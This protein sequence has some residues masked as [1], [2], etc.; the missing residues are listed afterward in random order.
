[1]RKERADAYK[2][3]FVQAGIGCLKFVFF[4]THELK[5]INARCEPIPAQP[6]PPKLGPGE[7]INVITIP[8][9]KF[10]PAIDAPPIT[11]PEPGLFEWLQEQNKPQWDFETGL[12]PDLHVDRAPFQAFKLV[13]APKPPA[14]LAQA[15][16]VLDTLDKLPSPAPF[17]PGPNVPPLRIDVLHAPEIAPSGRS[18]GADRAS[19]ALPDVRSPDWANDAHGD[20]TK[21]DA[22]SATGANSTG[23]GTRAR[24][25]APN[26]A[27]VNEL[28]VF[29]A[30]LAAA[31]AKQ[32]PTPEP[33][34]MPKPAPIAMP[35]V[36]AETRQ[37]FVTARYHQL[38]EQ[39][40]SSFEA[41]KTARREGSQWRPA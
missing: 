18:E 25:D 13:D 24:E 2:K 12:F 23:G 19:N 40:M 22:D 28:N 32:P 3:A 26:A 31:R 33:A 37:Q 14:E 30:A 16:V 29:A 34:P 15:P 38:I 9:G 10:F 41:S 4:W 8:Q 7:V 39:G 1:M 36:V 5:P 35:T 6:V 21:N 17:E 11:P 20:D 27:A